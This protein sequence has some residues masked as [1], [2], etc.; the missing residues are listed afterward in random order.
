MKNW[1]VQ[2]CTKIQEQDI[3]YFFHLVYQ[4]DDALN[5]LRD[6]I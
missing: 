1:K 2:E 6:H 4:R 3:I 5:V